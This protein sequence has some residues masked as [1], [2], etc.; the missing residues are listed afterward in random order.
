MQDKQIEASEWSNTG[1]VAK[2]GLIMF[3]TAQGNLHW[4]SA[5]SHKIIAHK[6]FYE[7]F[8]HRFGLEIDRY[9]LYNVYR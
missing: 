2:V 5:P 9:R 6:K 8:Q 7:T 1:W 3:V 4:G